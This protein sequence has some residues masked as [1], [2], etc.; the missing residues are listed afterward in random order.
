MNV[1]E[2]EFVATHFTL[3][4]LAPPD[5][6]DPIEIRLEFAAEAV[7]AHMEPLIERALR[8]EVSYQISQQ[9]RNK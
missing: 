9:P 4:E 5:T 8:E 2:D 3:D 6:A 7:V 1:I